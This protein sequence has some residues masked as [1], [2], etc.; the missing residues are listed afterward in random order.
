[1]EEA[2]GYLDDKD[3]KLFVATYDFTKPTKAPTQRPPKECGYIEVTSKVISQNKYVVGDGDINGHEMYANIANSDW[4]VYYYT[5]DTYADQWI[6]ESDSV[7]GLTGYKSD[8]KSPPS[9]KRFDVEWHKD[10]GITKESV[11]MLCKKGKPEP[12]KGSIKRGVY[13]LK[14]KNGQTH[15]VY[16]DPIGGWTWILALSCDHKGGTNP[17][18]NANKRKF[19]TNPDDGQCNGWARLSNFG[20]AWG[21]L[22]VMR[23]Y[24][25]TSLHGRKIHF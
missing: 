8:S 20:Y 5:G 19:T 14:T 18:I 23:F 2:S 15:K 25:Q 1:M 13:R 10:D 17:N 9:G 4:R 21:D 11:T 16:I 3:Y 22:Q 7:M 12:T 6:I 24:C